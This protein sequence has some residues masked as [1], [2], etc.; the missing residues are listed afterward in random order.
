SY[1]QSR[2]GEQQRTQR[3][4][5]GDQHL[6]AA[7]SATRARAAQSAGY[8]R[9]RGRQRECAAGNEGGQ[10]RDRKGKPENAPVR[11]Q[12]NGKRK[13]SRGDIA[14]R[15]ERAGDE[16]RQDNGEESATSGAESR[17]EEALREHLPG[18]PRS[19]GAERQ[20]DTEFLAS[21]R[22]SRQQ[23]PGY[24]GTHHQQQ[25]TDGHEQ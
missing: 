6:S 14:E 1:E 25:Q 3:D 24:V 19:R 21:P 13:A 16:R 7:P 9:A 15:W 2:R 11:R 12:V 18:Q 10:R 17:Q 4:L 20:T 22:N 8:S 5:E 23:E